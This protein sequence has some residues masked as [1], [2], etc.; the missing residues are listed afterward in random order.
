M[1]QLPGSFSKRHAVRPAQRGIALPLA[2]RSMVSG[3]LSLPFRGSFHRSLAVLCAIGQPGIFSLTRWSGQIPTTFHGGGGTWEHT[4]GRPAGFAYG[5]FTLYGAAF[6]LLLLP[7]GFVTPRGAG[8]PLQVCP[9]TPS[10]LRLPPWHPLGLGYSPFAR[11]YSGN[12]IRFLFLGLLKGFTSPGSAPAES[13]IPAYRLVGFPIRESTDHSLLAAPRGL[14]QLA[15]PF[16]PSG[17]RGI[18][19]RPLAAWPTLTS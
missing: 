19:H 12:R 16:I 4:S 10:G 14:S 15:T 18:H 2:C 3:S 17:C 13:G 7:T 1:P 9:T 5:T 8:R 6:Q 11:R